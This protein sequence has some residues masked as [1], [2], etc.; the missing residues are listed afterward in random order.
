M[1]YRIPRADIDGGVG[2]TG[3]QHFICQ[4]TSPCGRHVRCMNSEH[5]CVR[6]RMHV[7][8]GARTYAHAS[9]LTDISILRGMAIRMLVYPHTP[10]V[11]M[12]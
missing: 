7:H 1:V 3:R 8:A 2:R 12:R 9:V 5:A 6:T 10:D 4:H 11:G